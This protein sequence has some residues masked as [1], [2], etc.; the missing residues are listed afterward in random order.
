[1]ALSAPRTTLYVSCLTLQK[2]TQSSLL[3]SDRQTD[4]HARGFRSEL[5]SRQRRFQ[6]AQTTTVSLADQ[7]TSTSQQLKF[8]GENLR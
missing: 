8:H 1:M 5:S 2:G 6:M 4:R 3:Q 7:A